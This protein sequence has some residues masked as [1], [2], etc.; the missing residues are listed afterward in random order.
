MDGISR[1]AGEGPSVTLCGHTLKVSGRV[2]RHYAEMEAA[3]VSKRKPTPLDMVRQ[4]REDFAGDPAAFE[5]FARIAI[6]EAKNWAVVTSVELQ[7]WMA[8]TM[9]GL[10]FAVWLS[11]RDNDPDKYTLKKVTE[12]YMDEAEDRIKKDGADAANALR[13]EVEAAI[14]QASGQDELG[15]S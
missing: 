6:Q 1:V 3:I 8:G 2:L 4:S 13:E 14:D 11:V 15:N 12:L 7:E 5:V 9:T 10:M